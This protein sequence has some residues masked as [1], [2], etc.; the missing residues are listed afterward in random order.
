MT[1][2]ELELRIEKVKEKISKIENRITKWTNG[3]NDEAKSL[4]AACELVHDD[5]KMKAAYDAYANYKKDHEYDPTVYNQ[6]D[7]N[8]GPQFNDAY[9][10]YRD[11]AEAKNTL[12]KYEVALTKLINFNNAEKIEVIWAFLQDWKKDVKEWIIDGCELLGRLREKHEE[13]LHKFEQSE[14]YKE[15]FNRY[16]EIY[17]YNDWRAKYE[18]EK[19]FDSR[20]YSEVPELSYKFH[21]RHGAYDEK[22][23]EKFLDA[24]VRAKYNDLVNRITEKAGEII[25]A[26]GLYISRNGQINGIVIGKDHP[27]KVETISAGGYNIQRFHY[28]TLVTPI[29]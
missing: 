2:E 20:Y 27:V 28:R 7:W 1:K 15:K 13:E 19:V 26:S 9:N 4:A 8:K 29:N 23:L 21:T 3:M 6:N 24:Q 10:A 17:H 5:P 14:E 16:K 22:A 25:D 18:L 12:H 11:L